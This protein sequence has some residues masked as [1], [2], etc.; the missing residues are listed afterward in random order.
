MPRQTR[1][2]QEAQHKQ[3]EE[4]LNAGVQP[5]LKVV[6]TL[7]ELQP[8][9]TMLEGNP[10]YRAFEEGLV[11][12]NFMMTTNSSIRKRI[13]MVDDL[14]E[15]HAAQ[16]RA[17]RQT[18]QNAKQ[19]VVGK[20]EGEADE[21][22]E[23][24]DEEGDEEEAAPQPPKRATPL[25]PRPPQGRAPM[26]PR[27]VARARQALKEEVVEKRDADSEYSEIEEKEFTEDDF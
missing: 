16:A 15:G 9:L 26:P 24:D 21:D 5:S 11:I 4:K 6:F 18:A 20:E 1:E 12:H 23:E 8:V 3:E 14:R 22:E 10:S 7:E 19:V 13:A 17:D 2:E 27:P 25:P